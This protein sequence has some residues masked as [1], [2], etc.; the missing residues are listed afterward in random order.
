MN[1][2]TGDTTMVEPVNALNGTIQSAIT[3]DSGVD[4]NKANFPG[5][6]NN[7]ITVLSNSLF[8]FSTA[9]ADKVFSISFFLS[10]GVTTTQWVVNKRIASNDVWQI[11]IVAGKIQINIFS[12]G[13]S[14]IYISA[15]IDEVL[16]INTQYHV[17]FTYDSLGTTGSFKTYLNGISKTY[18]ATTA[19]SYVRMKYDANS[20]MYIGRPAFADA[21]RL[22]GWIDEMYFFDEELSQAQVTALQTTYLP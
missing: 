14:S 15:E 12:G 13:S 1:N 2:T 22:N 8:N 17:T 5:G 3:F 11:V 19:G 20:P 21:L 6:A 7:A 18:T 16:T 10:I 9:L 4:G